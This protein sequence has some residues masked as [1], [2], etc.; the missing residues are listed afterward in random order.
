LGAA[1]WEARAHSAEW[2]IAC[3]RLR[4]IA[5]PRA[6]SGKWASRQSEH[7]NR[8][9]ETSRSRHRDDKRVSSEK[10]RESEL[11]PTDGFRD[12]SSS[13]QWRMMNCQ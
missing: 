12:P 7:A 10:S 11:S 1:A 8:K 9:R 2:P 6:E 13:Y 4:A 3:Y 5:K